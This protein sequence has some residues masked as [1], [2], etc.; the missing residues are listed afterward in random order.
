MLRHGHPV[1]AGR[2]P[3]A[4]GHAASPRRSAA[5]SSVL[6]VLVGVGAGGVRCSASAQP[7]DGRAGHGVTA[8]GLVVDR[9]C[10]SPTRCCC[11]TCPT[12]TAIV[13]DVLV[14]H[15]RRRH[16]RLPRRPRVRPAAA[17][18][19]DLAQQDGRGA[20]RSA[21][22]PAIAGVWFAGP[23]PGLAVGHHALLLGA[24]RSRWSRRSAT[25]SSPTSSA[26]PARRTPA[27][28]SA[29]TAA[30]WTASTRCCSRPWPA[31]TSGARWSEP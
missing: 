9:R 19:A 23:L 14:G 10:R 22:S 2:L 31:T 15:V 1:P 21:S 13:I 28:C 8:L 6:L 18:A 27:R 11:A 3:R 24:R 30:R 7:Q 29:P 17:R 4:G 26:T 16:R 5:P 12:A 20:G 25:C